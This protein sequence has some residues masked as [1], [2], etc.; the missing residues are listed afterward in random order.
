VVATLVVLAGLPGTGKTTLARELARQLSAVHVRIDAIETALT[1]SGLM[2]AAA[3]DAAPDAG[4][5]LG[6][7]LTAEHLRNGVSVVADSVNPLEVTRAAW[8]GAG[9]GAGAKV[10]EM[11]VICS[12]RDLHRRRVEARTADIPDH[13]MPTWDQ[14]LTRT[15]LPLKLGPA[16]VQVDT[17]GSL[18]EALA[19][20]G[21]ALAGG[22]VAA[23][24]PAVN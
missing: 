6:Y 4:Y 9:E 22:I 17:A 14:V 3:W 8:R 20:V 5:R 10:I 2:D 21:T 16:A 11:E 1:V 15:Y 7:L 24:P 18:E 19:T 13:V 12:D 23:S